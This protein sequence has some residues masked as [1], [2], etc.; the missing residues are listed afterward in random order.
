MKK[1]LY[2][3]LIC[4]SILLLISARNTEA[5]LH[6]HVLA[7][8]PTASTLPVE[9]AGSEP[10]L[11]AGWDY[12]AMDAAIPMFH[13]GSRP[14]MK[15][16]LEADVNDPQ[17]HEPGFPFN[18]YQFTTKAING[19]ASVCP[20][21]FKGG[22][23]EEICAGTDEAVL[24]PDLFQAILNARYPAFVEDYSSWDENAFYDTVLFISKENDEYGEY[25]AIWPKDGGLTIINEDGSVQYFYAEPAEWSQPLDWEILPS[26]EQALVSQGYTMIWRG[27]GQDGESVGRANYHEL[28]AFLGIEKAEDTSES[29]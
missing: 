27:L 17:N 1:A 25:T 24:D 14:L 20:I 8:T 19:Y 12:A 7:A 4:A 23:F 26:D 18:Y 3:I 10:A 5:S 13:D 6:V 9:A 2:P 15:D 16:T 28:E 29:E 21:D 22:Y 11:Y